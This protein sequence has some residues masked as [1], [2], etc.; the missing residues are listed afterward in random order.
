MSILA[1]AISPQARSGA[2][3]VAHP[4]DPVLARIF[5]ARSNTAA[6]VSVTPDNALQL[7]AVYACVRIL[8]S[9]IAS[10]PLQMY[11]RLENQGR[12][13]ATTHPLYPV[14][15]HQPNPWQTSFEY[16]EMQVG[17]LLLRGNA[18]S[19]II[20]TGGNPVAE[21]IPLHP[22]RMEP[23]WAPNGTIAYR[24]QPEDGPPETLLQDEVHHIRGYSSDGLKGLSPIEM[25]R[26][27]IGLARASEE[28][29]SRFFSNG[30]NLGGV[31]EHPQALGDK[32]YDRLK[33]SLKNE[34]AGGPHNAHKTAI[35]EEGMKWTQ[36]GVPPD[37]AQFLETRKFQVAE[38]ARIFGVPPHM[39]ADMEKST[40]WGSG[41]EELSIGFVVY[42]LRPWLVR[43]EQAIYRD[44]L[45]TNGKRTFF[46]EFNVDGLLRGDSQARAE[47][48]SKALGS[49]GAPA[50]MTQDEVRQLENLN[51]KGAAAAEFPVAT[52][53]PPSPTATGG[54]SGN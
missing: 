20:S 32:A 24:Y 41:V 4:R 11:R 14:L 47:Y 48:Y 16:R 25:N 18:Y 36:I 22:D 2:V 8:S 54:N 29:G 30:A 38:I 40:T 23:F 44:L 26:E 10:L 13:L 45:T 19:R 50:W 46:A 33:E 35:L 27:S 17:H 6:G 31:F 5:G 51:P 12:T 28:F 15:H 37:Q 1:R 49:G 52:N 34:F 9:A 39:I 3:S 21:L 53:V 7:S 43:M 42:S